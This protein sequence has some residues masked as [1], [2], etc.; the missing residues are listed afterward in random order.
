MEESFL[1]RMLAYGLIGVIA[2]HFNKKYSVEEEGKL[3]YYINNKKALVNPLTKSYQVLDINKTT[4]LSPKVISKAL[5]KQLDFA[6]TIFSVSILM[7]LLHRLVT[8]KLRHS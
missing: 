1:L 7:L 6:T 4:P 2:H 8:E 5:Y 3:C